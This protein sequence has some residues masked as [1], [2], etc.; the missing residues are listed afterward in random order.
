MCFAPNMWLSGWG[1]SCPSAFLHPPSSTTKTQRPP[2]QPGPQGLRHEG[3]G[4]LPHR[5]TGEGPGRVI[6]DPL[7]GADQ[8]PE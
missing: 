2:A 7:G 6:E 8:L 5:V 4:L 3:E 1:S